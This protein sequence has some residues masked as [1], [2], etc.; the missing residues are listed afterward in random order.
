MSDIRTGSCLCGAVKIRA[1]IPNPEFQA[2]HCRQCQQWTGGGPHYAIVVED[3]EVSGADTLLTYR[4]SAHGERANCSTCGSI[5][6]WKMQDRPV[7]DIALGL[8]DDQSGLTCTEEI[9]V[10]LRP[11]WYAPI[12]GAAQR[13][14]AEMQAK[15]A[16]VLESRT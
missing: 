14:E 13:T 9:F 8:L 5:I 11:D 16:A 15:L 10:D 7:H 12:P 4:A 2:C 1:S 6:W 3:L